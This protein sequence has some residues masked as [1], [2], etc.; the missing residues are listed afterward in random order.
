MHK[1]EQFSKGVWELSQQ[2]TIKKSLLVSVCWLLHHMKRYERVKRCL[3][4]TFL[5]IWALL[6]IR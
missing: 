6:L 1:I 2:M 5:S 3:Q 4:K